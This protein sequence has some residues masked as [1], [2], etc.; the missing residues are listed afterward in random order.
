MKQNRLD[1][2]YFRE[3]VWYFIQE[4]VSKQMQESLTK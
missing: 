2:V 3:F 4:T 1:G